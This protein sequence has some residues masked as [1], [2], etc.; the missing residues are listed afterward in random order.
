MIAKNLTMTPIFVNETHELTKD[1]FLKMKATSSKSSGAL[2]FLIYDID[3]EDYLGIMKMDQ[4][5]GIQIN[6]VT[7]SLEVQ[8]NMLPN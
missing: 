3:G 2:F 5:N 1:L 4:N 6:K 8:E 7:F